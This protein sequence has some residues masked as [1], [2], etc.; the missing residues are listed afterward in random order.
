M[1]SKR[2]IY[3]KKTLGLVLFR[4]QLVQT[5]TDYIINP[6]LALTY[7]NQ[8][9]LLMQ[10]SPYENMGLGSVKSLNLLALVC[11]IECLLDF[12]KEIQMLQNQS[13]SFTSPSPPSHYARFYWH[14]K[15]WNAMKQ[16]SRWI[17]IY[18][19]ISREIFTLYYL[20]IY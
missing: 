17:Y 16:K 9:A 20:K 15:H 8:W 7:L 2:M 10:L 18:K 11:K 1:G 14:V 19:L 6:R 5:L 13:K 4:A 3:S 12:L